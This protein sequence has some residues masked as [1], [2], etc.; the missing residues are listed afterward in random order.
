MNTEKYNESVGEIL[1]NAQTKALANHHLKITAYHVLAALLQNETARGFLTQTGANIDLL[2]GKTQDQLQKCP[3]GGENTA[4]QMDSSFAK[5]LD[6]MNQLA[7][8]QKISVIGIEILLIALTELEDIKKCITQSGGSV[9]KL[10]Q[11]QQN[12]KAQ[13]PNGPNGGS[14]IDKYARDLT[15][16][17]KLGKCDPVIG[18]DDEIRR[19]MQIL[20]RRTKNNPLLIGEPGVGKTAIAEGLAMR[21]IAGDVPE[22]LANK[23]LISI[24]L[25]AILAGAKYRGEFE[26]RLKALLKEITEAEGQILCFIDEIH[27][28]VGAGRTDGAMDASNMLKPMLARGE[29]HCIGATTLDEYRQYIEKDPALARRFQTLFVAEPSVE[30]TISILRGLKEKYETHHGVRISDGA[31][32]AAAQLAGRYITDR[33]MPDKAIDLIDE[34]TARLKMAIDSKPEQIDE[35]ERKIMQLRI[36]ESALSKENDKNSILRLGE[37]R[38]QCKTLEKTASQLNSEWLLQ[39]NK[40]KNI[41]ETRAKLDSARNELQAVQRA[42][43]YARAGELTYS[44]IPQLEQTLK[45]AEDVKDNI[46]AH[47]VV[48]ERDI[49]AVVARTTGI[50]MDKLMGGEKQRLLQMEDILRQRIIGQ[51]PA[52]KALS[53]VVRRSRAGLGDNNRPIGSFLF[54][55]P[56]GVGKT[57]SCKALADFLFADDRA[58]ARFDMSEYMEKHAVARL[59]GA[60]PGYVGYEAGGSLTEIVRRRPY[61]ILLFDEIEKAHSDVHNILLQ[62]L[63][64]GRITD[65]QGNIVNCKNCIIVLTSNLGAHHLLNITNDTELANAHENIKR[66]LKMAFKPEFLNRLDEIIIF[67]KLD[68]TAIKRIMHN[69]CDDLIKKLANQ[70]IQASITDEAIDFLS[71][72]SYS[73]DYGARP[74]RR[75]IAQ[76]VQ[77]PIA[78]AILSD[79]LD[80]AQKW[81]I[82]LDDNKIT[83]TGEKIILN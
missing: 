67:N 6:K 68:E 63:D 43:D 55:G 72:E 81:V 39:K 44:V 58:I 51:D 19:T 14:A 49:A 29:L 37:I 77:N 83:I 17:A 1:Q 74:I 57:E 64:D 48:E 25:S 30:D 22:S 78:T 76:W 82:G 65:G 7:D 50:P 52:I 24:D 27:T 33:F 26:E 59:I 45:N 40:A 10:R 16:M 9:E 79:K 32:I 75:N 8:A 34:A 70:N 62:I 73:N 20:T 5:L 46:L 31:I 4:L 56:T 41:K 28:L 15:Q 13:N 23:R 42:G 35:L 3:V 2:L 21:I 53:D 38:E 61:Q 47:E 18:R 11:L 12:I 69:H 71:K 80:S 54:L 36:E 60:P 66:E